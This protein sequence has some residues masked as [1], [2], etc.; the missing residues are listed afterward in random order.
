MLPEVFPGNNKAF[1]RPARSAVKVACSVLR[2]APPQLAVLIRHFCE[3]LAGALFPGRYPSV[4]AI[5]P[6]ITQSVK[7]EKTRCNRKR[8]IRPGESRQTG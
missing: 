3:Q 5:V 8:L 2:K 7:T 1:E 4:P 6:A